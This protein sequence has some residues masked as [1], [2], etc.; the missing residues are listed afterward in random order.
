MRSIEFRAMGCDIAAFIDAET[1]AAEQ[2]LRRLP[3]WFEE[4]EQVFSRF[5]PDSELNRLN[6]AA[7]TVQA[8]SPTLWQGLGAALQA[9]HRTEGLVIP[10]VLT[11]LEQAG[12]RES[13]EK[14][15]AGVLPSPPASPQGKTPPARW[16]DIQ[17]D[18]SMHTV[19]LPAGCRLDLGGSA[20]GWAAAEAARRL[21]AAGPALVNA[22][23]DIAVNA[24]RIGGQPWQV[25]ISDPHN[26]DQ[27]LAALNLSVGGLAT[28]GIDYRRWQVDG[29]WRH[30]IIDPRSGAPAATDLLSVS[31]AAP[32][33][34]QAEAAAKA[35]LILGS[36]QGLDWLE[37]QPALAGLLVLSD[38]ELLYSSRVLEILGE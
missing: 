1:P 3:G 5:R 23:G 24:P 20:K 36:Q 37:A 16:Q 32:D 10:T 30:H 38:G 12:Y 28:S 15:R 8:V 14:L 7:G 35:V 27:A 22:G 19:C 34:L 9:A 13:F 18:E 25:D 21:Q 11:A 31:V 6:A 29:Q 4:W 33:V 17:L 2:A 26:P